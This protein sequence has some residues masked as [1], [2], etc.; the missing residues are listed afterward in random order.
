[1]KIIYDLGAHNGNDIPYYLTKA[2]K[3]IAVEANPDLAQ[4]LRERF[5]DEPRVVVEECAVVANDETIA[6]FY[7][8]NDDVRS[9][10]DPQEDLNN[11]KSIKV[12]AKNVVDLVK[13]HGNPYFIKIDIEFVDH[14]I[15]EKLLKNNIKPPYISVEMHKIEV[16][17]LLVSTGKYNKFKIV[18]GGSVHIEYPQFP[19]HAAGPFGEDIKGEWLD[20]D[21]ISKVISQ[22]G[23]GWKDLHACL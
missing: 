11:Y 20:S 17:S 18:D 6:Y 2:D 13:K 5:K 10:L 1:M 19:V 4:K 21:Q 7:V 22:V 16:F 12:P 3:V 23:T 14:L 8:H 9:G 15:L